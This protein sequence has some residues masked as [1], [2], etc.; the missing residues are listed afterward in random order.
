MR[1]K[2]NSQFAYEM[3]QKLVHEPGNNELAEK[4]VIAN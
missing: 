3:P 1:K 2:K 4:L